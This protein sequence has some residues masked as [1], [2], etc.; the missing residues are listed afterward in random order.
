MQLPEPSQADVFYA[1]HLPASAS[2]VTASEV[3]APAAAI[4]TTTTT[5]DT[6]G[7]VT[8]PYPSDQDALQFYQQ[9]LEMQ[10]Q[11]QQQYDVFDPSQLD[12]VE[13]G[14]APPLVVSP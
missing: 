3:T 4:T 9:Q 5:A 7:D 10:Q 1:A 14:A 11:Q 12:D 8:G 2:E 13:V 6:Y